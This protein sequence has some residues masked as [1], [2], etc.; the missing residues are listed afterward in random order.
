MEES[1]EPKVLALVRDLMFVSRITSVAKATGAAIRVIRDPAALGD[2][3][4]Q[5][6]LVDLN[7]AGAL[8]AAAAWR[9]STGS[10]VVGFVS[11]VD[12]ETIARA[13]EMGLDRV[14][15]R[16]GFVEALPAILGAMVCGDASSAR[17][18]KK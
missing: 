13:R 10:A 6:L 8:E 2:Q 1:S 4:S 12:A 18:L 15:A 5:L 9:R 17:D 16:S 14:M 11:H 7:L 3:A